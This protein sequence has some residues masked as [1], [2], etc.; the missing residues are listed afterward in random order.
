MQYAKHAVAHTAY[1][2]HQGYCAPPWRGP[3]LPMSVPETSVRSTTMTTT[4]FLVRTSCRVQHSADLG[5][6]LQCHHQMGSGTWLEQA[7]VQNISHW[8]HGG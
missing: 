4:A 3:T 2:S 8:L 5:R 7:T 1:Q 6:P